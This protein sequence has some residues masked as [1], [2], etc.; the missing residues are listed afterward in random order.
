VPCRSLYEVPPLYD[1]LVPPGP[2]EAFYTGLAR[3]TGG[4]VLELACGTGRLTIPLA[5][6]GHEV[7]G[8]DASSAMLRSARAKAR[9]ADVDITFVK[10]DMR[11]FALHRRFPLIIMTCNSL[12]H[13]TLTEELRECLAGVNRHLAP[14]GLFAF[15]VVNPDVGHLARSRAESVLLDVG[16]GWAS[17]LV[18]EEIASYDQ[19]QQIRVSQWRVRGLEGRVWDFA[20]LRLRQFFPQELPLLLDS[21]GLEL[22]C[23]YGDFDCGPLTGESANQICL[24]RSRV[25]A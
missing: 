13:L 7:M 14:G 2:C 9:A 19:V 18:V 15:D 12:A 22:A 21:A 3:Q 8:L 6:A 1:R 17:D 5:L 20:P 23:R 24:V 11:R 10:A 4:P 16:P 25:D